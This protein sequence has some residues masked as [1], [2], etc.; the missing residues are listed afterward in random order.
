ML[1]DCGFIKKDLSN[2]RLYAHDW[3]NET[4]EEWFERIKQLG[5]GEED[6]HIYYFYWRRKAVLEQRRVLGLTFKRI[7]ESHKIS[8][9]R[10]GQ[11]NA[12]AEKQ[13]GKGV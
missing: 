3:G 1:I 9:S 8:T 13:F 11:I 6:P 10:A 4:N 12:Q 7:G 5:F 2:S